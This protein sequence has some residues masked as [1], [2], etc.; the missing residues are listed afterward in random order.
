MRLRSL[1][2]VTVGVTLLPFGTAY[3]QP[4]ADGSEEVADASEGAPEGPAEAPA[5]D[6]AAPPASTAPGA[7]EP[8]YTGKG[9]FYAAVG[10]TAL[11][12]ISRGTAIGLLSAGCSDIDGCVNRGVGAVAFTAL[13]PIS[14][15]VAT[16]LVAPGALLMGRHH[17]WRSVT[18]GQPDRN[19]KAYTI[20]GGVIFGVFTGLSIAMRPTIYL[21][22][23]EFNGLCTSTGGII[24]Y[25]LGVQVSDTMSTVGMGLMTYGMGYNGYKKRHGPKVS[26][27]PFRSQYGSFGLSLSGRF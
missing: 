10:V 12:W 7:P 24:G 16:G 17:G 4:E 1:V 5:A 20:A 9:L 19:G 13:A 6:V 25:M 22:C 27:A 14:Q 2:V 26:V 15:F 23:Y 3:A 11:G 18:T 8:E 21:G